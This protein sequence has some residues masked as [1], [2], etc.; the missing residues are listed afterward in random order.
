MVA[1]TI[2]K[3]QIDKTGPGLLGRKEK[4]LIKEHKSYKIESLWEMSKIEKQMSDNSPVKI[5][6]EKTNEQK[7]CINRL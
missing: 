4:N 7:T 5:S 2:K 6:L 1:K 3:S